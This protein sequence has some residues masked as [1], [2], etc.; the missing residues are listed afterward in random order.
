MTDYSRRIEDVDEEE[1]QN[2]PKGS[3]VSTHAFMEGETSP[4]VGRE[5][6]DNEEIFYLYQ[7]RRNELIDEGM[8]QEDADYQAKMDVLELIYPNVDL[9]TFREDN[10]DMGS[11]CCRLIWHLS[12]DRIAN[13][14]LVHG[15]GLKFYNN[16]QEYDDEFDIPD[17]PLFGWDLTRPEDGFP[18]INLEE[19][20][21]CS[22]HESGDKPERCK[23]YPISEADLRYI[24]TC[25]YS[26]DENGERT[27]TCNICMEG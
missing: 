11:K 19:D 21:G 24:D 8:S 25:S 16:A 18:C 22:Y 12:L 1:A 20:G 3:G 26:F 4:I 5:Y 2:W 17:D 13:F 23:A 27:G 7:L 6:Y 9:S 15:E 10:S 14:H